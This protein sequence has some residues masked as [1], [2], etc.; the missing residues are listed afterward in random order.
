MYATISSWW[1]DRRSTKMVGRSFQEGKTLASLLGLMGDTNATKNVKACCTPDKQYMK[2][3]VFFL[4]ITQKGKNCRWDAGGTWRKQSGFVVTTSYIWTLSEP[5]S[6]AHE[7][8]RCFCG[9]ARILSDR[10]RDSYK[11][12]SPHRYSHLEAR[13]GSNYI[14]EILLSFI[15]FFQT[16]LPVLGSFWFP[17]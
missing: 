16:L 2:H 12:V 1:M 6:V 7:L 5:V 13:A 17:F 8:R 10:Q 15:L 14:S 3:K 4:Q 9:L 11:G